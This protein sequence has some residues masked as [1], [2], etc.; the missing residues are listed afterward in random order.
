MCSYKSIWLHDT[1]GSWEVARKYQNNLGD[2]GFTMNVVCLHYVCSLYLL[3]IQS[4]CSLLF[5]PLIWPLSLA[6]SII[7]VIV[8]F[9]LF[10]GHHKAVRKTNLHVMLA[11]QAVEMSQY[12]RYQ[13]LLTRSV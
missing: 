7:S 4:I 5:H 9:V 1:T 11:E 10:S 8:L 2:F 12:F 13:G 6:P 3:F